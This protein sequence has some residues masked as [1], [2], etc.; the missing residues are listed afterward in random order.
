MLN[1]TPG[2]N[3]LRCSPYGDA[4]RPQMAVPTQSIGTRSVQP[5]F[6]HYKD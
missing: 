5:V 6:D 2:Y 4:E 3:A 1:T